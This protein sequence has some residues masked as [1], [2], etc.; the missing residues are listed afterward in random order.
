MRTYHICRNL[1]PSLLYKT[2]F[3]YRI[4]PQFFVGHLE[5]ATLRIT[6]NWQTFLTNHPVLHATKLQPTKFSHEDPKL[7]HKK[8]PF[9]ANSSPSLHL[10]GLVQRWFL[11]IS[12]QKWTLAFFSE[13]CNLMTFSAKNILVGGFNPFQKHESK[14]IHLPQGSGWK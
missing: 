2:Q 11:P 5:P 13:N 3:E 10:E 9:Q 14:W 4:F 7:L 12:S 6:R 1:R 8:L